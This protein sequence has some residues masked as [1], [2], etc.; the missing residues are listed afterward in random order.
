[1]IILILI[2]IIC[3]WVSKMKFTDGYW[4]FREGY[5]QS[6]AIEVY[7]YKVEKNKIIV[8]TPF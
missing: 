3:K 7:D 8:Y 4:M 5:Q 6:N 2:E 1:M